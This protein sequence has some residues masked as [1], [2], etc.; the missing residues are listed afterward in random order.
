MQKKEK[1]SRKIEKKNRKSKFKSA[2]IKYKK[3][4]PSLKEKNLF[5][6]I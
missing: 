6:L 1:K 3:C 4:W 2:I 5:T